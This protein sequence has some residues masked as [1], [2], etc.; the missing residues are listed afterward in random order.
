MSKLAIRE[1][2]K[3]ITRTRTL[4]EKTPLPTDKENHFNK[5]FPPFKRNFLMKMRESWK[6][7]RGLIMLFHLT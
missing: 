5:L 1:K 7:L 3:I 6:S 2:T 4:E